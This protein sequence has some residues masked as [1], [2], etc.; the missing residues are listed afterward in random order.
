MSPPALE[1][2]GLRTVLETR[3]GVLPAVAGLNLDVAAGETL[4]LVGESGCGKS[5]TALSI[6]RLL[7]TPPA[8]TV[9]GTVRVAGQ[10]LL[11][12]GEAEMR[13]MRGRVTSMI[14]QDPI[15]S[16]NTWA[17]LDSVPVADPRLARQRR[18][19]RALLE[20]DLPS[21]LAPPSGCSFRTRCRRTIA[22]C[23]GRSVGPGRL[24]A[25]HFPMTE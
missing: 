24:V 7:Q 18:D 10:D 8:R 9:A 22:P 5:M 25:C 20:G 15:G 21:P 12:L 13:R 11:M 19:T 2:R 17:L 14:F 6:M 4:A 3:G 23:Y 1:V 16:L